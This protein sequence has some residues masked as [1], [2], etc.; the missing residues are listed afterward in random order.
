MNGEFSMSFW[1]EKRVGGGG[2]EPCSFGVCE[3]DIS[4][5]RERRSHWSYGDGVVWFGF[6][7]RNRIV[8]FQDIILPPYLNP[9][10]EVFRGEKKTRIFSTVFF[11]LGQNK[12][13]FLVRKHKKGILGSRK[14]KVFC[15][16]WSSGS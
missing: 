12:M 8:R 6:E 15:P 11:F 16:G 3:A 10:N 2:G 7:L 1:L 14:K 9:K 13:G 5:G 4:D